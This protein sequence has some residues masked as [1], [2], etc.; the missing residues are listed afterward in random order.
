MKKKRI[1][2]SEKVDQLIKD[3]DKGLSYKDI[4]E[5]HNV[6]VSTI[7]SKLYELRKRGQVKRRK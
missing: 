4:A 6:Q 2:W 5:K 3:F 1:R 7:R